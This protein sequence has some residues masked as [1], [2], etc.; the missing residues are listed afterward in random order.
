VS[1]DVTNATNQIPG[2]N[3]SYA[4]ACGIEYGV[5]NAVFGEK[6][7]GVSNRTDCDNFPASLKPGCQWRFDWFK[8]AEGP[9]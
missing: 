2:G 5:S 6:N 1:Y 7:V 4:G 9:K 3:T 8:D